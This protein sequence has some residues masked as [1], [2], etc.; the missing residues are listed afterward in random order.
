[1]KRFNQDA[2]QTEL[3]NEAGAFFAF[4]NRQLDEQK[5][6][7][8]TYINLGSGLICN[9]LTAAKLMQDLENVFNDKIAWELANNTKKEIIWY[10]LS[11]HECQITGDYSYV[12]DLLKPYGITKEEIKAEWSYY[13]D[14][15]IEHDYF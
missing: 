11:N 15:C 10:E 2:R 4:S 9:E 3:F 12:V 5:K 14:Y 13:F 6:E 7:G 8:I 1:M